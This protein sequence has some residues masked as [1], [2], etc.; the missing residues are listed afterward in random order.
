MYH[1]QSNTYPCTA[2]SVPNLSSVKIYKFIILLLIKRVKDFINCIYILFYPLITLYVT[3]LILYTESRFQTQLHIV[4]KFLWPYNTI[5]QSKFS[6]S[7]NILLLRVHNLELKWTPDDREL[8]ERDVSQSWRWTQV[9]RPKTSKSLFGP[10]NVSGFFFNYIKINSKIWFWP[11]NSNFH[12]ENWFQ[13]SDVSVILTCLGNVPQKESLNSDGKQFHQWS[14]INKINNYKDMKYV[15]EN[16]VL[17]L[18]QAQ[19]CGRVK[20]N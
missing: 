19:K 8:L 20:L 4:L 3:K 2:L 5:N 13:S 6:L 18:I 10:V 17:G 11:V 16:P 14:N 9:L 1:S 7:R 12:F 15:Y